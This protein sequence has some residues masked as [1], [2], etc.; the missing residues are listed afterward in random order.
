MTIL[1][2]GKILKNISQLHYLDGC[3]ISKFSRTYIRSR[4]TE[5]KDYTLQVGRSLISSLNIYSIFN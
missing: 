2:S 1:R 3:I 4:T 5:D